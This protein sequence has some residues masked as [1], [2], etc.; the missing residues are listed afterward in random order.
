MGDGRRSLDG[1]RKDVEESD[2]VSGAGDVVECPQSGVSRAGVMVD[3]HHY[4][5]PGHHSL[6]LSL[7]LSLSRKPEKRKGI[8]GG[9]GARDTNGTAYCLGVTAPRRTQVG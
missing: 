1:G 5:L 8:Y 2:D 3:D 6:Y 4:S 9:G 7:P